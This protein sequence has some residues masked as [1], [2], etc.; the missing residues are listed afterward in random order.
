MTLDRVR[1]VNQGSPGGNASTNFYF[2]AVTTAALTALGAFYTAIKTYYPTTVSMVI[3][4]SGDTINDATGVLVGSWGTSGG[5]TVAGGTVG[6]QATPVG[7][8]IA[9]LGSGI[10]DGHRPVGK[11]LIVPAS[12]S[13]FNTNG[14]ILNT[15]VT[16]IQTA[17]NNFLAASTSFGIWHRPVY[18]YKVDPPL[19]VRPGTVMAIASATVRTAP[20]VLR[21]RRS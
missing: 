8:E 5:S 15:A 3:P 14:T 4:S 20:T 19:L 16:A 17:A 9:W 2:V 18:N 12:S 11:T 10:V 13:T 7:F 6:I 21:S 1:V